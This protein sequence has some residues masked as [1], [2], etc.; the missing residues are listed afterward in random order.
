MRKSSESEKIFLA[1]PKLRVEL[2]AGLERMDKQEGLKILRDA[3]E[4]LRASLRK[5]ERIRH[6][7][8]EG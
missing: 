5:A 8:E 6:E 3:A 7:S 4:S 1:T 2:E